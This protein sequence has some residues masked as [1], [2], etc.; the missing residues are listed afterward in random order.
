VAT[1]YGPPYGE[2]DTVG[3]GYDIARHEIFFT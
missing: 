2:G 3:A 1:D